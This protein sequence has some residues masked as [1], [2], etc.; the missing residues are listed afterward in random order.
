MIRSVI[1]VV[2]GYVVLA[3]VIMTCFM[4]GPRLLGLERVFEPG[5]YEATALWTGI[6]MVLSLMGALVGGAVCGAIARSSRPVFVLAGLLALM[7]LAMA[8]AQKAPDAAPPP[9][10]PDMPWSTVMENAMKHSREPL[11][12]RITNPLLGF[13]GVIVGGMLTARRQRTPDAV[14]TESRP[15]SR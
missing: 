3:A 13:V 6:A 10:T 7:G 12:T 1:A 9:R 8:F 14:T 2:V 5:R 4:I 15:S 11:I